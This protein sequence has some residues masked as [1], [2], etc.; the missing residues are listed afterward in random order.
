MRP[1]IYYCRSPNMEHFNCW[2]HPLQ[3]L[4]DTEVTYILTYCIEC[5][6]GTTIILI[7]SVQCI[8]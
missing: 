5:V 7:Q 2:W 1:D 8:I 3:N 4:M 6:Y